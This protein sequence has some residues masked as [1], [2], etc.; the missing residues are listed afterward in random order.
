VSAAR[1]AWRLG[2]VTWVL[3]GLLAAVGPGCRRGATDPGRQAIHRR[4][5]H[6]AD[7]L[8]DLARAMARQ[9]N[10]GGPAAP[11]IGLDVPQ[12]E[13]LA[14]AHGERL[15]P[16]DAAATLVFVYEGSDPYSGR[17]GPLLEL[18]RARHPGDLALLALHAER[19]PDASAWVG[20]ALCAAAAVGRFWPFFFAVLDRAQRA[21]AGDLARQPL[22]GLATRLG[23]PAGFT[24]AMD[25]EPCR[26]RDAAVAAALASA[27]LRATPVI[28]VGGQ[29]L[30]PAS[31][32]DALDAAI[33]RV[34]ASHRTR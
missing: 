23:L 10:K 21:G 13:A 30:S 11:R 7:A 4:L 15:G 19:H 25:G 5:D 33:L 34:A 2:A 17:V 24:P 28:I 16:G 29:V 8:D 27:G 22:I 31:S 14:R 32:L 18:L 9:P 3:L 20:R 6:L 26:D 1:F 12:V